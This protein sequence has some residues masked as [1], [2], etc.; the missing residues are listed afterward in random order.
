[1]PGMNG[2]E[3]AEKIRAEQGPNQDVP[4]IG[5]TATVSDQDMELAKLSGINHVLRKPFDTDELLTIVEKSVKKESSPRKTKPVENTQPTPEYTLDGLKKMGDDRFV[6]DMIET[7]INNTHQNLEKLD[8]A[9]VEKNWDQTADVIHKIIA[10]VRHFKAR[11]LAGFLKEKE[12]AAR[13][14]TPLQEK[15]L[16]KIHQELL[17][18]VDSLQLYLRQ[19]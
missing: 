18:L 9:A 2:P 6:K 8:Q 4:I 10:P 1:M 16:K 12:L 5:L 13:A 17:A 7:F 11:Q 14:G 3:V 15:D 19:T